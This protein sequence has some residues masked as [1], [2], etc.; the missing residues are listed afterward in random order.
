[1]DE[2]KICFAFAFLGASLTIIQVHS[3]HTKYKP[4]IC[5]A[6]NCKPAKYQ[7]VPCR[8]IMNSQSN[9]NSHSPFGE[10]KYNTYGAEAA[11]LEIAEACRHFYALAPPTP[12]TSASLSSSSSSSSSDYL[13]PLLEDALMYQKATT[14]NDQQRASDTT[15]KVCF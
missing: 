12:N 9:A 1:M 5:V 3:G 11:Y 10:M 6:E 13:P 7:N 8:T 4:I 2:I 15:P 14:H